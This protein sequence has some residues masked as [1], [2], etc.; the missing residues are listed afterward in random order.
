MLLL[1]GRSS[2]HGLSLGTKSDPGL[3]LH[4]WGTSSVRAGVRSSKGLGLESP[5]LNKQFRARLN[6]NFQFVE[7]PGGSGKTGVMKTLAQSTKCA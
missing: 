6:L 4:L 1:L 7:C 3:S 2:Q 5:F